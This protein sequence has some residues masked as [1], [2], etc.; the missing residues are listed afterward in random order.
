[1]NAKSQGRRRFLKLMGMGLGGT[2]AIGGLTGW[3]R[4]LFTSRRVNGGLP[5]RDSIYYPRD[6]AVRKKLA[7]RG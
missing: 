4:S 5:S 2:L 6:D 1:M 7:G 3:W